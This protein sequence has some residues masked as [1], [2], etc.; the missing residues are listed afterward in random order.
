MG[1]NGLVRI[2][3]ATNIEDKNLNIGAYYINK[4]ISVLEQGKTNNL[5]N[6]LALNFLPFLEVDLV[7]NNL[8]NSNSPE[9]AIGDRQTSLKIVLQRNDF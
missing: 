2:P 1:Y 8:I 6:I 7:L 3:T 4:S 9:Q 5:R